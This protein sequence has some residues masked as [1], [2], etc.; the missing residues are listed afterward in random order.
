MQETYIETIQRLQRQYT[1]SILDDYC[2]AEMDELISKYGWRSLLHLIDDSHPYRLY[3]DHKSGKCA[4]C[5]DMIP[6]LEKAI[7]TV[8]AWEKSSQNTRWI[9]RNRS[10]LKYWCSFTYPYWGSKRRAFLFAVGDSYA[11]YLVQATNANVGAY[12]V[13]IVSIDATK[14]LEKPF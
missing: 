5:K 11:E 10:T 6:G 3:L 2:N 8:K 1:D 7:A 12:R 14:R 4:F 13:D 9:I